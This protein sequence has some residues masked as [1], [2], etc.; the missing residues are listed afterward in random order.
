MTVWSRSPFDSAI[1]CVASCRG[2]RLLRRDNVSEVCLFFCVATLAMSP[3]V[4]E[5]ARIIVCSARIEGSI[6][7]RCKKG[8]RIVSNHRIIRLPSHRHSA[9]LYTRLHLF[10]LTYLS[11]DRRV[12]LFQ[13]QNVH[14]N[15]EGI[16]HVCNPQRRAGE[17]ATFL[18]GWRTDQTR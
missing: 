12:N 4:R 6:I 16:R 3:L 1:R 9:A 5:V 7:G 10:F 18:A 2:V 14:K 8:G 15:A 17:L 13:D 11:T